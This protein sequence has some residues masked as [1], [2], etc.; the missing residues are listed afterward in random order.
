MTTS[1][2][3]LAVIVGV[4]PGLGGATAARFA[5]AG[6]ALAL[7]SRS[8][9]SRHA[10]MA[11][12]AAQGR[13][14][15]GYNC[16]AGDPASVAAA[17]AHVRDSQGHPSV[18]IYNAGN[19][20]QGGILEL[21]PAQ[22]EAAWRVN[23]FGGYLATRE[24]LPAMLV[25]GTGTILFTGA[26]AALRGG[27]KFSGLAVGKFGLRALAQSTA[28]EFGPRGIHVAHVVIDGHIGTPAAHERDPNAPADSMLDPSAVAESYWQLCQQPRSAW[29]LEMD[30]RP[31]VERF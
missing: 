26:T 1:T 22:F 17:F 19:F 16:D 30:L 15:Q 9:H 6:Y 25:A 27:A 18:L 20:V 29:T 13:Q 24:V 3:P 31:A 10:A 12:L 5:A 8:E 28:R 21:D 11:Q 4:G 14:T 23:C 7:L 2:Q